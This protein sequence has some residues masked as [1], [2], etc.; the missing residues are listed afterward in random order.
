[1]DYQAEKGEVAADVDKIELNHLNDI[2]LMRDKNI[3]TEVET[4]K[5]RA[6]CEREVD[7]IDKNDQTHLTKMGD[8]QVQKKQIE[9]ARN[10]FK[11][12]S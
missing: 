12:E 2:R 1:M 9:Q 10:N 3:E 6:D 7:N 5:I 4:R 11:K 8:W